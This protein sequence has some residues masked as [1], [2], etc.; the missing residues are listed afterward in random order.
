MEFR[1]M[2]KT[3]KLAGSGKFLSGNLRVQRGW[4]SSLP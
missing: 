3:T 2:G 4:K 1:A